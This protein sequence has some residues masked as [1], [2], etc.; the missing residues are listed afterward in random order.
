MW[1]QRG[2]NLMMF[3]KQMVQ[4]EEKILHML[5]GL[6]RKYYAGFKWL[7]EV[8]HRLE[9]KPENFAQRIKE[10]HRLPPEEA[11]ARIS[12]LVDETYD[13]IEMQLPDIDVNWLRSVFHYERPTWENPPPVFSW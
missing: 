2:P 8:I 10:V 11:A 6:N 4:I 1:Q 7:D 13:L 5:L 3:S 12:D 9:V